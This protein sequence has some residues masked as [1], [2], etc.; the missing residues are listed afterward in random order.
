ME[1][2][3]SLCL[4]MPP[5]VRFHGRPLAALAPAAFPGAARPRHHARRAPLFRGQDAAASWVPSRGGG[6]ESDSS[7]QPAPAPLPLRPLTSPPPATCPPND[8]IRRRSGTWR[9]R[10]VR[11]PAGWRGGGL[12]VLGVATRLPASLAGPRLGTPEAA[13]RFLSLRKWQFCCP[14]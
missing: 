4:Q 6:G 13:S 9:G 12:G 10:R 14:G 5:W 2:Q 11:G 7:V 1:A 8:Q 3:N